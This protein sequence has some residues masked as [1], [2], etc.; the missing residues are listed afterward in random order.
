MSKFQSFPRLVAFAGIIVIVGLIDIILL[1]PKIDD[2]SKKYIDESIV[3]AA[4]TYATSRAIN[5][6]VSSLQESTVTLSPWGVGLQMAPGQILDPINDAT[7]RL[8]DLCA[9]SLGILAAH[10]IILAAINSTTGPIVYSA[11][12]IF[13]VI[14]FL[15]KGTTLGPPILRVITLL[16]LLR[17]SAPLM[18][19]V[20]TYTDERYFTPQFKHHKAELTKVVQ[21][22]TKEVAYEQSHNRIDT[23]TESTE[24]MMKKLQ[25]FAL[26]IAE[27]ARKNIVL[28]KIRSEQI[29]EAL[30]YLKHHLPET[31]DHLTGLFVTLLSKILI[32]V[33]LIPLTTLYCLR[34]LFKEMTNANFKE[35][36]DRLNTMVRCNPPVN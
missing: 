2:A 25:S 10:R 27:T 36:A 18:T 13:A 5:A 19:A 20:G 22:V 29:G 23:A 28:A 14:C 33:L 1:A 15:N 12:L 17:I 11:V 31:L 21:I 35:L 32:Q 16:F 30:T 4:S 9:Q 7:E 24:G 6:G 26:N 34:F 8:S 3:L